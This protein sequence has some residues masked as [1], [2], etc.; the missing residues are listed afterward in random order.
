MTINHL[1]QS[2]QMGPLLQKEVESQL[3]IDLIPYGIDPNG[4]SIDWTE[5]CEEGHCTEA[6]DGNLEDLSSVAVVNCSG[7]V[8]AEGWMD[9]I[10]DGGNAPLYVFWLF[11]G[12]MRNGAWV[13]MKKTP[14]IPEHIWARLPESTRQLCAKEA[15]YGTRWAKDPLVLSWKL[16]SA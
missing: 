8:I 16:K 6:I 14:H 3:L 12:V 7:E 11:L 4:L 10:H 2:A 5:A 15:E 9:F 13:E 1:G